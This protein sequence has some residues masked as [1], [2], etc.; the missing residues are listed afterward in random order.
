MSAELPPPPRIIT[1]AGGRL[2]GMVHKS[3]AAVCQFRRLS[4]G[5]FKREMLRFFGECRTRR[6]VGQRER[7]GKANR[8][9]SKVDGV[10]G[11]SNHLG[12][13]QDRG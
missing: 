4:L 12:K 8:G 10:H 9:K 6:L 1:E 11:A 3:T 2:L 13:G 5:V 7:H